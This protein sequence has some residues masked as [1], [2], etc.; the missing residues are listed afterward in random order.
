M[1][2]SLASALHLPPNV[3]RAALHFHSRRFLPLVRSAAMQAAASFPGVGFSK[4]VAW[5]WLGVLEAL[6]RRQDD[7]TAAEV[8]EYALY[9]LQGALLDAAED[10]SDAAALSDRVTAAIKR[11]RSSAGR[12]PTQAEIASE[13]GMTHEDYRAALFAID[14]PALRL[15]VVRRDLFGGGE[16]RVD[17]ETALDAALAELPPSQRALLELRYEERMP[18]ERV[19]SCLGVDRASAVLMHVEAIHRLRAAIE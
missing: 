1:T 16:E 15:E 7:L 5:A 13:L 12:A 18:L 17:I 8:E 11:A 3:K 4:L 10:G 2:L 19:A 9:R 6:E 14:R